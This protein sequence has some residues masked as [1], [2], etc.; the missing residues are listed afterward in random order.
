MRAITRLLVTATV[1]LVTALAPGATTAQEAD[2]ELRE[3]R[4]AVMEGSADEALTLLD[5]L[6]LARPESSEVALWHGHALRRAGDPGAAA[7]QYLGALRLDPASAGALIALGDLQAK[8]GDLRRSHAYYQ[9]AIDAAPDFPLGYRRAAGIEVQLVLHADAI[10]HL[11]QYL[12]LRPGDAVAM[13]VLGLEQYLDEDVDSA[14]V[15]LEQALVLEPDN[16]QAQFG[17]GMALADRPDDYAR[18]IE[19]LE[20]AVAGE[21]DNAMALYLIG[22]IQASQGNLRAA[23]R[24]LEASLA[25][26]PAQ[27]DAHYRIALVYARLGE[28]ESAAA[29]QR[30]FQSLSQARDDGEET[31]RRIELLVEAAGLA[32]TTSDFRSV[33]ASA[34]ELSALAPDDLDVLMVQARMALAMGDSDDVLRIADRAMKLDPDDWE[35]LYLQGVVLQSAQPQRAR[36]LLQR[37]IAGNPLYAPAFAALGNALIEVRDYALARR[38]YE[39]AVMLAPGSAAHYLNLAVVYGV[40]GEAD[41]EARA[42]ATHRRLLG[43]Q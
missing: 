20:A 27:A 6:A 18:A 4:R 17:L 34:D 39:S 42:M 5:A 7:Q 25:L 14:V 32:M 23:R 33:R 35:A 22:K 43:E 37:A 28:R 10:G 30:T 38:A 31:G 24:A 3:A 2:P 21:P 8:T 29:H 15:T 16:A 41:L 40:L 19:N 12:E 13:R 36:E 26:D 9:R 11:R 1:L